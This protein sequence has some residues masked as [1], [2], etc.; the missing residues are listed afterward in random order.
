MAD[1]EINVGLDLLEGLF[2]PGSVI[3]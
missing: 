1:H 3:S 2:A